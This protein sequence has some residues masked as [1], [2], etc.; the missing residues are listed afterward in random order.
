VLAS[1]SLRGKPRPGTA[2]LSSAT[3]VITPSSVEGARFQT[4]LVTSWG[5]AVSCRVG[6]GKQRA[7]RLHGGS[8]P[9]RA[10]R[11]ALELVDAGIQGKALL[12]GVR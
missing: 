5:G 12:Q 7:L 1:L 3:A 6:A 4:A 2:V 11:C 9:A 8:D 10:E